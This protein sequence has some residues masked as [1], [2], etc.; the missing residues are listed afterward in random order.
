ME[1]LRGASLG[2]ALALPANIRQGWKELTMTKTLAYYEHSLKK[3]NTIWPILNTITY[4]AGELMMKKKSLPTLNAGCPRKA[5]AHEVDANVS[6]GC[7]VRA[8]NLFQLCFL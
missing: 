5:A 7:Q 3:F 8:T 1:Q 6:G 2:K 4:F